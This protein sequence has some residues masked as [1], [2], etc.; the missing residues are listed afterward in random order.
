MGEYGDMV[1]NG[2]MCEQ[3]GNI[4][5]N[6]QGFPHS[7]EECDPKQKPKF[8]KKGNARKFARQSGA[9]EKVK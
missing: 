2:D 1:L 7:C 9:N 4:L 3:C 8:E 6:A 5:S